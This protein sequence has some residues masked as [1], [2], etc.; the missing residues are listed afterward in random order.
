VKKGVLG[1]L[2]VLAIL[3]SFH[4]LS[5]ATPYMLL[6]DNFGVTVIISDGD[7]GTSPNHAID[8]NP[9]AGAITYIGSIGSWLVNVTTGLTKP[10]IG[11]ETNPQMDL[12]SVNV[13]SSSG[14]TIYIQL[15]DGS[16]LLTGGASLEVGGTTG[17]TVDFGSFYND[18]SGWVP[19]ASLGPFGPGAFSGT[20]FGNT[21]STFPYSL[22]LG[23]HITHPT[24]TFASSFD[25]SLAVPEPGVMLLL[26]FGLVGLWGFRRKIKK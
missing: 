10:V 26:G 25:A 4:P 20:A 24:G 12:N 19:I 7:T 11:S 1:I 2:I 16:F 22:G 3:F 5:Y 23:V 18:G 9:A 15:V 6:A 8:S 17:G 13:S 14:G 21:G